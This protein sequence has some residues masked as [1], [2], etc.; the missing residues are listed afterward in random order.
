MTE[1]IEAPKEATL[2]EALEEALEDYRQR[3]DYASQLL[4]LVV[5]KLG[6]R[7]ELTL[8]DLDVD[9]SG[10]QIEN[11]ADAGF[12]LTTFLDETV[13]VDETVQA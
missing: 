10:I 1:T 6:G 13:A 5:A 11:V 7:V 4:S 8:E 12:V 2:E 9:V 3:L